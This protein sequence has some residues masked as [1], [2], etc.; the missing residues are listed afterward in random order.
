MMSLLHV[1]L[2]VKLL[3]CL[4]RIKIIVKHHVTVRESM[5]GTILLRVL[6]RS[7]IFCPSVAFLFKRPIKLVVLFRLLFSIFA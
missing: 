5:G 2:F 4:K 1:I 7:I 3:L 6:V